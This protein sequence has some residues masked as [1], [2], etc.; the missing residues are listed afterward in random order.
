MASIDRTADFLEIVDT[1]AA[2]SKKIT[3][4]DLL[5]I[6]GSPVGTS[7]SQ[8]LTNKII[9]TPTLTV[10]DDVLTIQDNADTTK[11][12]QFQLSG[13]TTATTR[14]LTIPNVSDTLVTLGA[15]QTLTSKTLTSPI[16]NTATINNPTLSVNTV[17]EFTSANGVTVDGLNIKDS[18][19]NTNNSVPNNAWNNTGTFGSSWAWTSWTPTLTNITLGNGTLTGMY[20]QQGKTVTGTISLLCGSTTSITGNMIFSLPVTAAARYTGSS[21]GK[22]ML[23]TAYI[24]DAGVAAYSGMMLTN[25]STTMLLSAMNTAGTYA[26]SNGAAAAVPFTWANGDFFASTFQYEAL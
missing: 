16:I 25:S 22:I 12:L 11:K 24:E 15:T 23:G 18:A 4:N 20:T 9:T 6:T 8:T 10:N 14:T 13:I 1:S 7:D 3:P 2:Q 5:G 26:T 19:L 17:S 21:T